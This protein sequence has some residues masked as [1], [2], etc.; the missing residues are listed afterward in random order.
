MATHERTRRAFRRFVTA[1]AISVSLVLMPALATPAQAHGSHDKIGGS[2]KRSQVIKRARNWVRRDIQ[3]SQSGTARDSDRHHR[4]RRD[5]S[6]FISMAWHLKRTG[7]SAPWTGTLDNYSTRKRKS[8][9]KRGDILLD[10][11]NHAVIFHKWAN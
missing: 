8:R 6:G 4:Y 11:G 9:L 2:I 3:Y 5:C 1:A 7:M 10:Q